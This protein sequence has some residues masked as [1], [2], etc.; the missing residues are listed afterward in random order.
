MRSMDYVLVLRC[1]V[2]LSAANVALLTLNET[3]SQAVKRS[4]T[5]IVI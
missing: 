3:V 1:R 5:A 2:A 4:S